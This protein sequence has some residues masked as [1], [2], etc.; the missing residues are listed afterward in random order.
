MFSKYIDKERE[1]RAFRLLGLLPELKDVTM[2]VNADYNE[3][4][5]FLRYTIKRPLS[6][7]GYSIVETIRLKNQKGEFVSPAISR[8]Y[9]LL[10]KIAGKLKADEIMSIPENQLEK[11]LRDS[12]NIV[13]DLEIVA[14]ITVVK[15]SSGT[16]FNKVKF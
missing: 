5:L 3:N 14:D 15:L 10:T 7:S 6:Y 4:S 8:L 2:K 13:N 9:R 16:E 12:A 11:L 1:A